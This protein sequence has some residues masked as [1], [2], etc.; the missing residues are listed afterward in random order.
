MTQDRMTTLFFEM[1]T[2]LPRQ[3]PGDAAS[4][5][6]ALSLVPGVGAQTRVLIPGCGT[7]LEARVIA[8]HARVRILAIDPRRLLPRHHAPVLPA[9]VDNADKRLAVFDPPRARGSVLRAHGRH[10]GESESGA[11]RGSR[12]SKAQNHGKPLI[13][14]AKMLAQA[15]CGRGRLVQPCGRPRRRPP[16]DAPLVWN[17]TGTL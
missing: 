17:S 9:A 15:E 5:L 8:G 2:G 7:G 16:P 10:D 14:H 13:G 4:T 3:G 11:G 6:R 12:G 1:F